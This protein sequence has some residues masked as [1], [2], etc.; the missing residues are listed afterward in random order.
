VGAAE[1]GEADAESAPLAVA[2]P[3]T[4]ISTAYVP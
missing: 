1:G 3:E 2:V 4:C